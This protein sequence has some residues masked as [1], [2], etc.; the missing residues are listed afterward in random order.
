LII[1]GLLGFSSFLLPVS[2]PLIAVL[3]FQSYE[4]FLRHQ[5]WIA[6][7][8]IPPTVTITLLLLNLAGVAAHSSSNVI[9]FTSKFGEPIQLAIVADC[10]GIW[11]LG[12]FTVAALIVLSSFPQA[13]SKKGALLLIIGY[14]GTYAANIMRVFFI[15]LSGYL[16]GPSGVIESAHVHIGWIIFSIWMVIFWYIF[17]TRYL[18]FTLRGRV[19]E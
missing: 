2:F 13:I 15:S 7:P 8:L 10:T 14:I 1:F 19:M 11:S 16:Y 9:M 18:N 3:G 12:T 4:L 5:E 17:F 6:A